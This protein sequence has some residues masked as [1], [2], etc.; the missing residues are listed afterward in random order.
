MSGSARSEMKVQLPHSMK[1]SKPETLANYRYLFYCDFLA[2]MDDP[3][4]VNAVAH[5][6]EISTFFR[7]LG[8]YPR[9]GSLV[10]LD[11]LGPS[12]KLRTPA[13]TTKRKLGILG[14][15]TFGQFMG[16]KFATDF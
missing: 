8:S 13:I 5:L 6:R 2:S 3:N 15:G 4:S 11:A 7:V 14:F 16:K 10:G 9:G 12:L 1:D